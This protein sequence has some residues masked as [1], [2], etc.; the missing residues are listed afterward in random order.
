MNES[1]TVLPT[2]D[3]VSLDSV[4]CTEEL[5]SRPSRPPNYESENIALVALA[6][7]LADSPDTILQTMADKM[8]VVL[9]CDS[10][11]F[12]LLTK[13][14]KKFHWAA[15]AGAWHPHKGGGTPRE[16]GPCGDVLDSN[17]PLLKTSR[18]GSGRRTNCVST[19]SSCPKPT[20]ARTSSWR[21]WP[22]SYATR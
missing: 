7:A 8:L 22:T 21:C 14:K 13:D 18:S 16:F 11:G 20:A 9:E 2:C 10:A 17:A 4:L 15:I 5:K 3:L 19:P 6:Q 1:P 12:S